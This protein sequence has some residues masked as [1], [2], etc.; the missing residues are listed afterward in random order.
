VFPREPSVMVT[1]YPATVSVPVRLAPVLLRA[2]AYV[3]VPLPL[4]EAPDVI[5][6]QV[7]LLFAVQVQPA[8]AVTERL[9]VYPVGVE[10]NGL[11][12]NPYV[13]P[14]AAWVTVNE[15]PAIVIV[16]VRPVLPTF[17]ATE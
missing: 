16:P 10:C 17:A 14:G 15:I 6:I 1:V 5:V 8:G 2:T 4:P 12:L 9:P 3:T 11:A 7:T 13:Q